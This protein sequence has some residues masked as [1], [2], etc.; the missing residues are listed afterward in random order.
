MEWGAKRENMAAVV[1][2]CNSNRERKGCGPPQFLVS[3]MLPADHKKRGVVD[4]RHEDLTDC[5]R[6]P[7]KRKSW[8]RLC[9]A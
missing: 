7:N 1:L 3:E 4:E 9:P 2:Y 5:Y 6:Q 8:A